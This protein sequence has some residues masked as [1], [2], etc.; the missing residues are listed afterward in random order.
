MPSKTPA[1]MAAAL[2]T[3]TLAVGLLGAPTAHAATAAEKAQARRTAVY[4]QGDSL[5]VGAGPYL[6]RTLRGDVKRVS[7]DA[8]VGRFTA[9][10]MQRLAQSGTAR[11][12]KVWVVALG[13]NDGP[14]PQALKRHV[15]RSLKLAGPRREVIWL[16]VERPGGYGG[17]NRM[18]RQLD[19]TN[20]RLHV[21]DWAGYVHKHPSALSGDGVHATA[22]GYQVR[23][24]MIAQTALQ[25]AQNG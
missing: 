9:T 23:A 14:D 21:V 11:G 18:L 8:Q 20:D 1:V 2:T 5:T 10:G 6:Q 16:T 25:L 4:V 12:A 24:A 7:V 15:K 13:T 22:H 19:G 17:V 3:A